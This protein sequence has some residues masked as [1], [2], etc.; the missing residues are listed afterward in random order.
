METEVYISYYGFQEIL[1]SINYIIK[2]ETFKYYRNPKEFGINYF[3]FST[4]GSSSANLRIFC[5]AG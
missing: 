3:G 2:E 5:I 1:E 4:D